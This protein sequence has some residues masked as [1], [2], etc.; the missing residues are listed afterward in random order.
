MKCLVDLQDL[1]HT[2][3]FGQIFLRQIGIEIL[4]SE[5]K[6]T[7]HGKEMPLHPQNCLDNN[8]T[9]N[10]AITNEPHSTAEAHADIVCNDAATKCTNANSN[11][12][13]LQQDHSTLEL[14]EMLL[15]ML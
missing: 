9:F 13:V 5:S 4:L 10:Q 14:K 2:L 12:L 15:K 11:Q 1:N 8:Q 7:R 6:V 3:K